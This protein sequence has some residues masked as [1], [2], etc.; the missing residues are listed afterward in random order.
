[1]KR[2]YKFMK[3][4]LLIFLLIILSLQRTSAYAIPESYTS[5]ANISVDYSIFEGKY[6][7]LEILQ[8]TCGACI[9]MHPII[10]D[11]YDYYKTRV[12]FLSLV[13]NEA[14]TIP[15]L[16]DFISDHPTSWFIG[17]DPDIDNY[18]QVQFTPTML[19]LDKS[20]NI[21]NRW[22]SAQDYETIAASL[23]QLSADEEVSITSLSNVDYTAP[24]PPDPPIEVFFSSPITQAA[25]IIIVVAMIYKKSISPK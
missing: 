13:Y 25:I 20:G 8:T 2:K 7:F 23:D 1:M 6:L 10:S 12:S 16:Q 17:R 14:D 5:N 18:F 19:V 24:P 11:L 4:R 3:G 9:N 15:V 22:N 21:L